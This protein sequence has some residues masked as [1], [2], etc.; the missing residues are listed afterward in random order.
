MSREVY[1]YL[2][3]LVLLFS[4]DKYPEVELLNRMVVVFFLFFLKNLPMVFYSGFTSLYSHQQCMKVP[5][6]NAI[7]NLH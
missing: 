4:S 3:E 2:S 5:F 6:F 7:I 1:I